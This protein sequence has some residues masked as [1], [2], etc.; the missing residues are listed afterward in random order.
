VR[1]LLTVWSWPAHCF[2]L[3]PRF[4]DPGTA[5]QPSGSTTA[6]RLSD[7]CERLRWP[8]RGFA[9]YAEAV[10]DD[11]LFFTLTGGAA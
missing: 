4:C 10:V 3:V 9:A 6:D 2:P 11:L 5:G 1:V 8:L 7:D